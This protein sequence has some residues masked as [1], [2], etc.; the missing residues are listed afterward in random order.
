MISL[1]KAVFEQLLPTICKF[2]K[3]MSRIFCK[4]NIGVL[5]IAFKKDVVDGVKVSRKKP[6]CDLVL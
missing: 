2:R 3:S 4:M 6:G 1:S 5:Y